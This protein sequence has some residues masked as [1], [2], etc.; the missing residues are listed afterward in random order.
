MV[1]IN[2]PEFKFVEISEDKSYGKFI[3]EPLERGYGITLG[4]SL[5]RVLLST[6]PGAAITSIKI[7][8]VL[9]EFSTIQGVTEDVTDIIL[10]LKGLAFLMEIDPTSPDASKTVYIDTD[11]QG[12]VTGADI[13]CDE[14]ITVLNPDHHIATINGKSRLYME[15]TVSRGRG[16][17]TADKNKSE[18]QPI[19]V[20]AIDSIFTPVAKVNYSVEPTRVGQSIDYDKLTLE[21]WTNGSISP[22]EALGQGAK[23]LS[24]HLDLFID[25]SDNARNSDTM[26]SHD[27]PKKDRVLGM[28]IEELELSVRAYNCLKRAGINTVLDLTNKTKEQMSKV[29]NLGRKSLDEVL[30]K[31]ES[32]DLKLSSDDDYMGKQDF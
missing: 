21:I 32:L 2:K 22:D 13:V 6:L 15:L 8:G 10:N 19:G 23:I 30:N 11:V 29:R 25:L 20:I 26:I 27:E 28:T 5:R 24:D 9:H 16:Y 4:N 18:S 3:V 17:A 14:Q 31:L 12:E 7:D 1:Q